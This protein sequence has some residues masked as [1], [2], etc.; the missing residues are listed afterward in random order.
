VSKLVDD[1]V[2][3]T[4]QAIS[5]KEAKPTFDPVLFIMDE[6]PALENNAL[7]IAPSN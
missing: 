5:K 3:E 7:G 4:A 6:V 1:R 2:K